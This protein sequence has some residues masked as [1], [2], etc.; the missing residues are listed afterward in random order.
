MR[1]KDFRRFADDRRIGPVSGVWCRG[2]GSVEHRRRSTAASSFRGDKQRSATATSA[3]A[4]CSCACSG[5]RNSRMASAYRCVGGHSRRG[6]MVLHSAPRCRWRKCSFL[7]DSLLS[8][9]GTDSC[10]AADNFRWSLACVAGLDRPA[11]WLVKGTLA[12]GLFLLLQKFRRD[13]EE[14]WKSLDRTVLQHAIRRTLSLSWLIVILLIPGIAVGWATHTL[15][16]F[17]VGKVETI[18][19]ADIDKYLPPEPP[20][21]PF[22]QIRKSLAYRLDP[23]RL[24]FGKVRDGLVTRP[25]INEAPKRISHAARCAHHILQFARWL[26]I[27][28]ACYVAVRLYLYVFARS[29]VGRGGR[30]VLQLERSA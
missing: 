8:E 2:D 23:W 11:V 15:I 4:D 3:C 13:N 18:P 26:F 16:E 10:L 7:S 24:I 27:A 25:G 29:F 12:L 28:Y 20:P 1:S 9:K 6:A 30:V 14:L 22:W 5:E 17:S 21:P 19:Q